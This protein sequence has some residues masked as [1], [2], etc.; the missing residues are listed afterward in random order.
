MNR[1]Q[2]V[3][4]ANLILTDPGLPEDYTLKILEEGTEARVKFR[5][6]ESEFRCEIDYEGIVQNKQELRIFNDW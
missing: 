2:A 1:K 4:L 5:G 3:I 6:K